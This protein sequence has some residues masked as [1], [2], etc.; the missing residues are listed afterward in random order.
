MASF[1]DRINPEA[2]RFPGD[3][4][5]KVLIVSGLFVDFL[6]VLVATHGS[7]SDWKNVFNATVITVS[8]AFKL[9][10]WPGEIVADQFGIH[11]RGRIPGT[12]IHIPWNE[13][14]AVRP[15][16]QVPGF[17]PFALGLRNDTLELVSKDGKSVIVHTP[18]HPDRDRLL[19]EPQLR[20]VTVDVS[21]LT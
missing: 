9:F 21:A 15:S 2:I 3:L 17:G 13:L 14:G 1:R 18:C 7:E 8:V 12:K 10:N 4:R 11:S 16:T 20:G 6:C 19:R 5:I